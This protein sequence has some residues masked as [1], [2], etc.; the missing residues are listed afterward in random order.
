V[1]KP[2]KGRKKCTSVARGP[3]PSVFLDV[4]SHVRELIRQRTGGLVWHSFAM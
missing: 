3:G 4:T 2:V 1:P